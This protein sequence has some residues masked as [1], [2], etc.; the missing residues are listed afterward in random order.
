MALFVKL[1]ATAPEALQ[2]KWSLEDVKTISEDFEKDCARKRILEDCS[3][4]KQGMQAANAL[5]I[6]LPA[7][8][9][10]SK[11]RRNVSLLSESLAIGM[12]VTSARLQ[13]AQRSVIDMQPAED[14]DEEQDM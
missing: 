1:S 9:K 14:V 6:L 2:Q 10:T 12:R 13:D 4:V 7:G 5:S 8:G 3:A 11:L